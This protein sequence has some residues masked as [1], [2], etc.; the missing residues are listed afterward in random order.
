[1]RLGLAYDSI[2]LEHGAPWHPESRKRLE[3]VMARLEATGW[4]GRLTRVR[5]EAAAEEEIEWLHDA[6]YVDEIRVIAERGGGELDADTIVT[7]RTYEAAT[8][9]VG[10]CMRVARWVAVG[11]LDAG[12]CA[13]RP[14]GHHALPGRGM[15][16]CFF[17]NAALAA[18][19][20]IRGGAER[21]AIVDFDVH[22]GN[23]TQEMFYHRGDVLY[24]SIH[25]AYD[26]HGHGVFYPGTGTV[27]EIGVDAGAGKTI[28]IPLP[29]GA[30]DADYG[31]ALAQV[32]V[33]ALKAWRPQV[34]IVSAGYDLHHSDPLAGMSLTQRGI[35]LIMRAL[36]DVAGE[37]CGGKM[38]V[39]LEGGYN[40]EAT[41]KGV[42]ETLR[43]MT[44]QPPA[45][46]D[47]MAPKVDDAVRAVVRTYLEHAIE[48]HRERLGLA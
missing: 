33:P 39:V 12:F 3:A 8:K 2:F 37:V 43:A 30:V 14:P 48:V 5:V 15:G 6:D 4:L 38:V 40:V 44:G 28:N 34:L 19:A 9:A 29:A 1:M 20:L 7:E 31:D 35:H 36:T 13:V 16:F 46:A 24:A 42:E 11:E 26:T 18:E 10:A 17:N 25:Q 32:I 45:H 41:A 27:D 21:I 47:D 23:G 22:H